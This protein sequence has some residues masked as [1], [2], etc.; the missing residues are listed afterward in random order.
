MIGMP[1]I[2]MRVIHLSIGDWQVLV[3]HFHSKDQTSKWVFASTRR[4]QRIGIADDLDTDVSV[5]ASSLADHI[6]N[7]RG[8]KGLAKD[9]NGEYDKKRKPIIW[10]ASPTTIRS[11]ATNF[12]QKQKSRYYLQP[13]RRLS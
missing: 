13:Q 12:F 3:T 11:A 2:G 1:P 7:L 8:I 6:R 4:V 9:E 5:H 10:Q